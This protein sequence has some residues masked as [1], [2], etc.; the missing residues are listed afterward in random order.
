[1]WSAG[2]VLYWLS[3]GQLPFIAMDDTSIAIQIIKDKPRIKSK[4]MDGSTCPKSLRNLI[5]ALLDK[6]PKRRLSAAQAL[7]H[8]FIQEAVGGLPRPR[9]EGGQPFDFRSP[10]R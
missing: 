4:R 1:M 6:N 3:Y 8:P 5:R 9:L 7:A 2:V 10:P